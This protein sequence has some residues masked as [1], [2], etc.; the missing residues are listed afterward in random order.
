MSRG[1]LEV[2]KAKGKPKMIRCDGLRFGRRDRAVRGLS[3]REKA[4]GVVKRPA[5]AGSTDPYCRGA[6][7]RAW[8]VSDRRNDGKNDRDC[9]RNG[10]RCKNETRDHPAG[11]PTRTTIR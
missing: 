9:K 6:G 5:R 11:S 10:K 2:L 7:A 3:Q 1:R 4:I 8:D